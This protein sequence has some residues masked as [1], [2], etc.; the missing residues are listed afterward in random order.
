MRPAGRFVAEVLATLR[1]ETKVGTNLLAI[2]R[3]RARPDPRAPAPSPATSTTTPRSARARSARSS[4]PRSTTPCCTDSRIDYALRD[5]DL[6]SLDFAVVRRRL[7]RRLGRLVRRGHAARRGSRASSTPTERALD[8]AI[9]A[10]VVGQPD[11]RHLAR[12]RATSRTAR[13]TRSTPTSAATASAASCTATRTCPT[14]AARAAGYPLRAGLVLALEPWFLQTH[15]RA[16]HRPDGWTL[17]SV[18]GSRG[19]HAEHTIAITDDGPDRPDRPVASS[20]V[21]AAVRQ[22]I[23]ASVARALASAGRAARP[24]SRPWWPLSSTAGTS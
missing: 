9:A 14:T 6:V 23:G 17:R 3:A 7:G 24:R 13:A 15:G 16:R 21:D 2:D 11:R 4:A 5:G 1:D 8:A 18:D 12:D 10:A 20:V 19:A 22:Q